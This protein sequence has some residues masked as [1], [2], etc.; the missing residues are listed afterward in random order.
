GGNLRA[1][2]NASSDISAGGDETTSLLSERLPALNFHHVKPPAAT[3][4]SSTRMNRSRAQPLW[5]PSAVLLTARV[6]SP[7]S[8]P[9]C[10]RGDR[11]PP[12]VAATGVDPRGFT[13]RERGNVLG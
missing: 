7:I 5:A 6:V 2:R 12:S 10:L 1:R 13:G 9:M 8:S 4:A 11:V 3:S